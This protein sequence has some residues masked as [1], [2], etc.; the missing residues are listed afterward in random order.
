MEQQKPQ[1]QMIKL[2]TR[3]PANDVPTTFIINEDEYAEWNSREPP[4]SSA[5][6]NMIWLFL[7]TKI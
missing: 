3:M 4:C 5:K 6:E 7:A 2:T 1:S